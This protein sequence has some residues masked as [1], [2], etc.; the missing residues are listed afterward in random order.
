MVDDAQVRQV[1]DGPARPLYPKP[2]VALL[3]VEEESFVKPAGTL[4]RLAA[5]DEKRPRRPVELEFLLV[6][7]HPQFTASKA[8]QA[9]R[10]VLGPKRLHE[11][12]AGMREA[13]HRREQF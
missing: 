12:A 9:E 6:P 2:E 1:T 11:G 8:R 7:L 10:K 13:P 4:Q 3:G 5:D